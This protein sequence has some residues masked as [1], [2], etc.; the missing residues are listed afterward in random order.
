[1]ET[2]TTVEYRSWKFR[3]KETIS[4][5][6]VTQKTFKMTIKSV[7]ITVEWMFKEGKIYFLTLDYKRN[8]KIFKA[9]VGSIYAGA[10]LVFSTC[11]T[12]CI[13]TMDLKIMSVCLL[14]S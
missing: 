6:P 1:M 11:E 7:R 3:T 5:R 12:F 14:S 13:R 9:P 4:L 10:L 2:H 8:I